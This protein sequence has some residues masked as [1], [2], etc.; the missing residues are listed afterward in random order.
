MSF[1]DQAA[2][3]VVSM[4]GSL[5]GEHGDGQSRAAL[6]PKMF[7]PELVQAFKEFKAIWDP[8]GMM[9]PH[10]IVDPYR[11]DENLRFGPGAPAWEPETHFKFPEDKGLFSRA[12]LRCVGVGECRRTNTHGGTMCPSFM[13]TREEEHTTRG[14][15]HLMFE[16]MQKGP[17]TDGW[18]S[19]P[20][21]ES[22]DL[23]LACKG[24][25]GDCPVN[26]DMATYK[27][28]FLSHYYEGRL[29]PR[30]AYTMGLIHVWARLGSAV[31]RLAN[32]VTQT[33]GLARLAK[34]IGGIAGER[35]IPPFAVQS[36]RSWFKKRP[37]HNQGAPRVMLWA[38]TFNN[39]FHPGILQAA[40]TVLE[41]AG[42]QVILPPDNACCGRPLYDWGML[43]RAKR[44]LTAQLRGLRPVLEDNI[45]I[46]ALEPSCAATFRDE[47]Q[48]LMPG[49]PLARQLGKATL[50]LSEFLEQKAP[51]FTL[52]HLERRAIV[53]AHC[54]HHAIMKLT[55]EQK[56][57]RRL[58]LDFE[59]LDSGCCGMAGSFGF[60]SAHYDT[61]M[62]IGE[63]VL[64]PAVR[65]A[66]DST[67]IIADGF[68]CREQIAQGSKRQALHLAEV[69][70][71]ALKS[72]PGT[73]PQQLPE[74]AAPRIQQADKR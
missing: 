25:K 41:V 2:D 23:C 37:L 68:S 22:L 12:A 36:F 49:E 65:A 31:P 73:P 51:S 8:L 72:G 30:A 21:K 47:L 43:H 53:Q 26:V 17:I 20:V 4:R 62:K 60:E 59:I 61:S 29:R 56:V 70:E 35:Q 71:L 14:R 3:L 44:L 66:G 50:L 33:P 40:V 11:P 9:N 1:L 74:R 13:V 64:L 39:Y 18:K 48:N 58:G 46:V 38:D 7:G 19:E 28:E 45:P 32:F 10:K 34:A 63:R 54:H 57:L 42:Y 5:S 52:P 16:M 67:L 69:I 24:C 55:D 6:L 27:S 15:A